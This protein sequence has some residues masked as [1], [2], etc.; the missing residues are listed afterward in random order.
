MSVVAIVL[1]VEYNGFV[2]INK[3]LFLKNK[4]NA[5]RLKSYVLIA[6]YSLSLVF[7]ILPAKAFAAEL[8]LKDQYVLWRSYKIID[9]CIKDSAYSKGAAP[10]TNS[11]EAIDYFFG[12][13][14]TPCE[15]NT[16]EFYNKQVNLKGEKFTSY[17]E[18]DENKGINTVL[19]QLGFNSIFDLVKALDKKID[20]SGKSQLNKQD[21]INM[22]Q[23][24]VTS[25]GGRLD[26]FNKPDFQ[27]WYWKQIYYGEDCRGV[28]SNEPKG[29][30]Y[31]NTQDGSPYW[32]VD[33]NEPKDEPVKFTYANIK[34][35]LG[36]E[37]TGLDS[38]RVPNNGAPGC[39]T[40]ASYLTKD[41][42]T[43]YLETL[44]KN[45]KAG[46]G[47]VVPGSD[48]NTE[49]SCAQRTML[50]AGWIVCSAMELL[51]SGM[52]AMMG[53][54][55]DML[56][57][58]VANIDKEN[59]GSLYKAWSSF[60]YIATLLLIGVAIVMILSQAIGGGN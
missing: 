53:Y 11:N 51:S 43:A 20:D 24:K 57:V 55:E 40:V 52:N 2:T 33:D 1:M 18:A 13:N 7:A 25:S 9:N 44:K 35:D 10:T 56:N 19:K 21:I 26:L 45:P 38:Y 49:E 36:N 5:T 16:G 30:E 54:I 50:S 6:V 29:G 28:L 59:N 12:T 4:K 48:A 34:T 32:F 60:R 42:A 27:Y 14:V 23:D 31:N 3:V 37:V 39:A 15:D 41:R 58:D 22:L 8:S 46:E 17:R 47:G